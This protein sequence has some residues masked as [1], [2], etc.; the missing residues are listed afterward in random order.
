MTST[1]HDD[2]RTDGNRRAGR[3]A[4]PLR[5]TECGW[6]IVWEGTPEQ[7]IA[8]GVVTAESLAVASQPRLRGKRRPMMRLPTGRDGQI[9]TPMSNRRRWLVREHF[10]EEEAIAAEEAEASRREREEEARRNAP[11]TAAQR[12]A[13]IA[14]ASEFAYKAIVR[15][16]NLDDSADLGFQVDALTR[17]RAMTVLSLLATA[18][19]ERRLIP[20][21]KALHPTN[22][23]EPS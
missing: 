8:A 12:R 17:A 1:K 2:G 11:R 7:L 9:F 18:L 23:V 10:T 6:G 3:A 15:A 21:L 13:E 19:D 20:T 22:G 4:R 5:R 16:F 14:S